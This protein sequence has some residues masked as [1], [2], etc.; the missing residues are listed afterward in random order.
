MP[1]RQ[2][3]GLGANEELPFISKRCVSILV[4]GDGVKED[5][6]RSDREEQRWAQCLR[7]VQKDIFF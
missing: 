1:H 4:E 5:R 3:G 6:S 7:E 2:N